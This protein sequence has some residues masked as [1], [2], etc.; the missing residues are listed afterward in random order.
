MYDYAIINGLI[1]DGTRALAYRGGLYIKAGKIAALCT[2]PTLPA[3]K[4]LDAGGRAVS[5]GFIDIHT[6]S[7][8]TRMISPLEESKVRQGV[9][10]ELGGHCGISIVPMPEDKAK[11][12]ELLAEVSALISVKKSLWDSDATD[13]SELAVRVDSDPGAIHF[14][15]LVG[16]GTLRGCVMGYENRPPT[17]DELRRMEELLDKLL[18]QGAFGMSLGLVYPPGIF[19]QIDELTALAKV[20]KRHGALLTVHMRNEEDRIFQSLEEMFTVAEASGAHLHI[21]HV[22]LMG[23][24]QWGW[25]GKVL[26]AIHQARVKGLR[27][28]A[29]Q[30]P[31]DAS[32]TSLNR[33]IPAWGHEGG[34]AAMLERLRDPETRKRMAPEIAAIMDARGGPSCLRIAYTRSFLPEIEEMT[35]AGIA[36]KWDLPPVET[37]MKILLAC[38][39][40]AGIISHSMDPG[41][42]EKIMLDMDISIGSDGSGFSL[43]PD[44]V[45]GKPHRRNFGTFP[46]FLETA[47]DKKL[48]SLEDAVHKI[49]G[50][51]AR[52]MGLKDRGVLR[53]GAAADI[54]V[55]DPANVRDAT[56]YSNPFVKP[57]GIDHVFV[58]GEPVVLHGELTAARNGRFIKRHGGNGHKG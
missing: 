30:Y 23:K 39:G 40:G 25:S 55:F 28:T 19:S 41:D 43:N 3:R 13:I 12:E 49:T 38:E 32:S 27:V 4:T 14:S 21:S 34:N 53:A 29:D 57:V 37:V 24:S 42:V 2:D 33:M 31:Y 20:V 48:L 17:P 50:L 5:P 54:T 18:S 16:H 35:V 45:D 52:A 7:D 47:R 46:F 22:K 36:E 9:T 6:H 1:V 8:P 15:M 10:L 56:T 26:N 51:P 44:Q 58:A 11:R